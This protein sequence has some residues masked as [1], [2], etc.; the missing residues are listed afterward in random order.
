MLLIS[1]SLILTYLLIV[2][3]VIF[4]ALLVSDLIIKLII[5]QAQISIELY[6][7]NKQSNGEIQRFRNYNLSHS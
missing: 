1:K 7:F 6:K 4:A 5:N 2:V 3:V